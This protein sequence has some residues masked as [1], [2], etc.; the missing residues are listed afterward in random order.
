MPAAMEGFAKQ[1]FDL[2]VDAA[3]VGRRRTLEHVPESGL[4]AQREGLLRLRVGRRAM[5]YW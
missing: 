5:T 4:E 3:Q 2:G 1:A